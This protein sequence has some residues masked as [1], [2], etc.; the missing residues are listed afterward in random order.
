MAKK[1]GKGAE[2]KPKKDRGAARRA[3]SAARGTKGP[4][5]G[6]RTPSQDA[7]NAWRQGVSEA[8]A[9][10]VDEMTAHA[11]A[12]AL[13]QLERF[14][15]FPAFLINARR[16][17]EF[18]LDSVDRPEA[19]EDDQ[20]ALQQDVD[21]VAAEDPELAELHHDEDPEAALRALALAK[22]PELLGA[23]LALPATL[24]DRSGAAALVI[25]VEHRD[26]VS[27]TL[28]QACKIAGQGGAR[29]TE[30]LDPTVEPRPASLLRRPRVQHDA[31]AQAP[32]Q[33]PVEEEA[34]IDLRG[35][36][37]TDDEVRDAE[38][39]RAA[40]TEAEATEPQ[41]SADSTDSESSEGST[42]SEGS[43]GAR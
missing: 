42:D 38:A 8:T 2:S 43:E 37:L 39:R 14:G 16:D 1:N 27:L 21:A 6:T 23:A 7:A 25:E 33:A 32:T 9:A 31:P 5:G 13:D 28:V 17:G 3:K 11:Q 24:P 10:T 22:A 35:M 36:E 29:S 4:A 30:L 19:A 40:L 15:A 34:G 26:G 41:G 20:E 18:E 12:V